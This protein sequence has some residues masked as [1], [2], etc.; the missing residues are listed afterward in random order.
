MLGTDWS[1]LV[2]QFGSETNQMVILN[3]LTGQPSN[4]QLGPTKGQDQLK[5]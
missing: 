5:E 1:K 2:E 4:D 3:M